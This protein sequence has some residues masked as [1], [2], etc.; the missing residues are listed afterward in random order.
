VGIVNGFAILENSLAMSAVIFLI[1]TSAIQLMGVYL[2][3]MKA[4]VHI[5]PIHEF[6]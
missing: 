4:H 3:K 5:K 1:Y 6:L 2:R